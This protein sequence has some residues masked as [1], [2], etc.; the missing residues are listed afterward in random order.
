MHSVDQMD[1]AVIPEEQ[2]FTGLRN[3]LESCVHAVIFAREHKIDLAAS[4]PKDAFWCLM[5]PWLL[6][7]DVLNP[8]PPLRQFIDT[9]KAKILEADFDG[10]DIAKMLK[11]VLDSDTHLLQCCPTTL[12]LARHFSFNFIYDAASLP[13]PENK[14]VAFDSLYDNFVRLTYEQGPFRRAAF[15]H[16]FNLE[17]EGRD[18]TIGNVRIIRLNPGFKAALLKQGISNP[19]VHPFLHPAGVGDCFIYSVETAGDKMD[20]AWL[21]EKRSEA[22]RFVMLLQYCK[23]GLVHLGYTVP[24]FYPEWAGEIRYDSLF[25]LGNPRRVP[26]DQGKSPY[27]IGTADLSMISRYWAAFSTPEI[28]NL[29]D[30]RSSKVRQA[31]LRA[32]DYYEKS[33]EAMELP[34]RLVYLAISLEALFSPENQEQLRFRIAHAAAQFLGSNGE[35]KKSIFDDLYEFYGRRSKLVHGGYPV[36]SYYDGTF[37]TL[38]EVERWS[39]LMRRAVLGFFILALRGE[40][41]RRKILQSLE[42]SAFNDSFASDIHRRAAIDDYLSEKGL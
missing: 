20:D 25:F 15:T 8:V 10:S 30:D 7:I 26:H 31:I 24:K 40:T 28:A 36:G 2:R 21:L 34:E 6:E 39:G 27:K 5:L 32:G 35:N 9:G 29:I 33:H 23:D 14:G 22:S 38:V 12:H 4:G 3:L 16:I 1:E 17:I 11:T 37:V 41:D 42:D 19:F 13:E 18:L